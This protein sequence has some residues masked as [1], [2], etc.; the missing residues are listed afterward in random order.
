MNTKPELK[1]TVFSDYI[2][3]FCYVGYHRLMKLQDTFDL[4]IHWCFIEIHPENS[5]LGESTSSLSYPSEQWVKLMSGLKKVA[6][7]ENIPIFE[8]NF[9]TNSKD[10]IILSEAT[11]S[12]G[13]EIFYNLHEKIFSRF[14]ID[15][16]NIG[17]RNIL[18]SIATECGIEQSF[19]RATWHNETIQKSI[20]NNVNYA[21]KYD[22]QSV[23]SFV[24]GK[25]VLTGVVAESAMRQAA[26]KELEVTSPV[27]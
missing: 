3:P 17:D 14:F 1:V 22:I 11:K 21:K 24:F 6:K 15:A 5:A 23:P 26:V 12:L 20:L 19:V 27:V 10:A 2:C 9:T 7:E 25:K 13:K 4:K 16:K 8:H 18:E